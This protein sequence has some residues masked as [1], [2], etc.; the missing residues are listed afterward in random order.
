MSPIALASPLPPHP[1]SC[2]CGSQEEPQAE[3]GSRFSLTHSAQTSG[4]GKLEFDEFKV[5]WDKLKT[6]IVRSL[7]S[8]WPLQAQSGEGADKAGTPGWDSGPRC[9]CHG[10]VSVQLPQ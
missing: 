9:C 4:N 5:F 2:S 7:A 6:W 10:S 3:T 8:A 1:R